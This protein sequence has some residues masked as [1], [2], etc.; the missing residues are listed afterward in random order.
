MAVKR[1][2]AALP[3][4]LLNAALAAFEDGDYEALDDELATAIAAASSAKA[5]RQLIFDPALGQASLGDD[6]FGTRVSKALVQSAKAFKKADDKARALAIAVRLCS[7]ERGAVCRPRPEPGDE[8]KALFRRGLEESLPDVRAF[9]GA[10]AAAVK[11]AAAAV[12]AVVSVDASD[13]EALLGLAK[14]EEGSLAATGLMGAANVGLRSGSPELHAKVAKL[15]GSVGGKAPLI[16][17]VAA[18]VALHILG[19][20]PSSVLS[21][22]L[23]DGLASSEPLP[24]AWGWYSDERAGKPASLS[25]LAARFA[26]AIP[27]ERRA[28]LIEKLTSKRVNPEQ[29][30]WLLSVAFP[31][32]TIASVGVIP[33]RLDAGQRKVLSLFLRPPLSSCRDLLVPLGYPHW[34]HL[35]QLLDES[36]PSWAPIPVQFDGAPTRLPPVV[37]LRAVLHDELASDV[38]YQ[39]LVDSLNE[40]ALMGLL[41]DPM[42]TPLSSIPDRPA[43]PEGNDRVQELL[44]RLWQSLESRGMT[45]DALEQRAHAGKDAVSEGLLLLW[46]AVEG[47]GGAAELPPEVVA[48][49]DKARKLARGKQPFLRLEAALTKAQ[50]AKL[51]G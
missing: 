33:S 6:G 18:G 22:A 41:T 24:L 35:K 36:G 14:D 17:R 23:V 12:I 48:K 50:R 10:R 8:N 38:A 2:P 20:A 34:T 44:L 1:E 25:D 3:E 21:K 7:A 9:L 31:P 27:D 15:A 11:V 43:L 49:L 47:R 39:A 30:A 26:Q 29:A 4:A 16:V 42:R 37:I 45:P 46:H 51:G 5:L 19:E 40:E 28:E 32:G 13:G